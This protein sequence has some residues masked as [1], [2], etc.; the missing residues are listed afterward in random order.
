[1]KPAVHGRVN[2]VAST[3]VSGSVI[4]KVL[5]HVEPGVT[6]VYNRYSYDSEKREA[7]EIWEKKLRSVIHERTNEFEEQ[8]RVFRDGVPQ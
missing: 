6:K 3:G 2:A 7:L 1:M 8:M 5:N 4:S